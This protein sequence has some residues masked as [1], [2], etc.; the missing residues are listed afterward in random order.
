MTVLKVISVIC[1]LTILIMGISSMIFPFWKLAKGD[2]DSV[3]VNDAK[4]VH[5][6]LLFYGPLPDMSEAESSHMADVRS[7]LWTATL[8]SA[9]YLALLRRRGLPSRT[10]CT[11]IIGGLA[12]IPLILVLVPFDAL[13]T[14]F[15]KLFFPQGNWT[16]A[17]ESFL[18]S[19]FGAEFFMDYA[20]I[21]AVMIII[22]AAIAGAML[23]F[24]SR[25]QA[26]YK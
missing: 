11:F 1:A 6:Y 18:I 12:C 4:A 24:L 5:G 16:F 25:D 22:C 17:T 10:E 23:L 20:I 7:L 19:H 8:V 14:A 15:H 26:K 3:W 9:A 21:I 2:H 13:F